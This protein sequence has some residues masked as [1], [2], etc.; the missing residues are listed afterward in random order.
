M[1][2]EA[3]AGMEAAGSGPPQ[4]RLQPVRGRIRLALALAFPQLV[5][6]GWRHSFHSSNITASRASCDVA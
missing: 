2:N 5:S 3:E 6:P 1:R 4:R